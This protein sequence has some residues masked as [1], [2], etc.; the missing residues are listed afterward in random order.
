[1]RKSL[2]SLLVGVAI[3]AGSLFALAGVASAQDGST[4]VYVL[5]DTESRTAELPAVA[6]AGAAS[7]SPSAG[8]LA[9]TGSDVM[10][11]SAVGGAA[12]LAGGA[13]L[14]TRRRV[15]QA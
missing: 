6:S 2:R 4:D 3:V 14:F 11:L 5:S 1:M 13:I 9:F 12:V 15:A 8:S 7:S 10:V